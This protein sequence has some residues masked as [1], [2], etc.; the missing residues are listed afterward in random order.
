MFSNNSH[1]ENI[2]VSNNRLLI[3]DWASL[4]YHQLHALNSKVKSSQV[5]DF[6]TP[7]DELRVWR[8]GM[9]SKMLRYIKLF[10][11]KD[12]VLSKEGGKIWR[13]DYVKE[14]YSENA[15]VAYD[16]TGYYLRYDNFLYKFFKNS[17]GQIESEKLD[18]V[19]DIELV[20]DNAKLLK[21]MPERIQSMCWE[22]VLPKYKGQRSKQEW[23]FLIPRNE[24]RDYKEIFADELGKVFR[25]H[26][27]GHPEA[28]G[29]DI[30]YVAM[31]HW[32]EKY[33]S[34][35]LITRDSD[36]NQL[37]VLDKLMIFNHQKE[38]FVECQNPK[39]FCE[40][41]ILAG[42]KSDN[43]NGMALPGKKLQLGE[44]TATKLFESTG[45]IYA[46]SQHEGWDAQY[47]RN[48][49]L[50]DLNYIPTHVQREIVESLDNSKP[51]ICAVEDIY[52]MGYTEKMVQDVVT[53]KNVGYY[54]LNTK[55]YIDKYPDLF[56]TDLL[57]VEKSREEQQYSNAKESKRKFDDYSNVFEVPLDGG[58]F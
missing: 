30:I 34:I 14:W 20:P 26:V 55:E 32:K 16:N 25:A 5:V 52:E 18:V 6:E 10:N 12:I 54:A 41:K 46:K 4:S 49:K 56:N 39:T 9:L 8:S 35:V 50:I 43:I 53:M 1:L 22:E 17:S 23:P 40:V 24:W 48:Q 15:S 2:P 58:L 57:K 27:I 42:D 38:E 13:S 28:E 7:E 36:L 33:D 51:E 31:N 47:L 29:D 45:N 37:K 44:K 19:K 11:P 3:V 21:E